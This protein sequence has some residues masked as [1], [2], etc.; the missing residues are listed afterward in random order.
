MVGRT[1][2]TFSVAQLLATLSIKI[3]DVNYQCIS[4]S[5]IFSTKG[6]AEHELTWIEQS[7][8]IWLRFWDSITRCNI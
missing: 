6:E 3:K 2:K 1:A 8:E 4:Y 5:L 7:D